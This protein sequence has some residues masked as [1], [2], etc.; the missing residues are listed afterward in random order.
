MASRDFQQLIGRFKTL[1]KDRA[2][3]VV[4]LISAVLVTGAQTV[5]PFEVGKDQA[6]QL[7]VS[8]R[9][10]QGF[11]L[12]TT[13]ALSPESYDISNEPSST[14]VTNWPPGLS[15]LVATLLYAGLP[16]HAAL[17]TL[18]ATTTLLGWIGWAIIASNFISRPVV[19]GKRLS[20]IHL[21]IVALLPF[22]STPGWA[23]TDV[24]LWAGV[25]F[26]LICLFGVDRNQPSLLSVAFAGLLFG[27]LYAM[28]YT[29]LFIGLAAML[30]LFQVS[31]PEIKLFFKR[32]SVFLLSA[33]TLML[34]VTIYVTQHAESF[35]HNAVTPS[36]VIDG[37]ASLLIP[38]IILRAMPMTSNL[39]L[40][41]P[42][43]ERV[44]Y[45]VKADWL[46]YS[47]GIICLMVILSWPILLWRSAAAKGLKA[48]DDI[49]LS[50]SF[51]PI[52][53]VIFLVVVG[54][55]AN[56]SFVWV[57]RYYEAIGLC[58]IFIFYEIATK[59]ATL[60][61][62]KIAS[63]GILLFF[64]LYVCVFLPALAFSNEGRDSLVAYARGFT[65]PKIFKLYTP[66]D[67][68]RTKVE[69]LYRENP[70]ALFYAHH[71]AWFVYDGF[72]GGPVPGRNLRSIP[73]SDFWR[74]AYTTRPVKIFWIVDQ[75]TPLAFIPDSKKQLIFSDSSERMKILVSDFPAGPLVS[76][77]QIA[78]K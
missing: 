36:K 42:L 44:V 65:P 30:I 17:K 51:L 5:A 53:M 77:G 43:L 62:V 29:S 37:P 7:E 60:G 68:A 67:S 48:K 71:Y 20:W 15:L 40:G 24:F 74:R 63:K 50:L 31:Y 35:T 66:K 3:V 39:V 18:Y 58:G 26:V 76:D 4:I 52:S 2:V 14:Y 32:F 27:S 28:R 23:G 56:P 54:V 9:L 73:K 57:R 21:T 64:V 19:Y 34:P 41:H 25:P 16:L 72:K 22:V 70:D 8:R 1:C 75:K 55:A 11:G 69:Q 61:I 45:T 59:R 12:T 49:A 46:I 10:V 13:N 6:T 78:V 38:V 47:S 33:L